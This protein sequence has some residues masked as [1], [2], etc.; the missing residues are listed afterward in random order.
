VEDRDHPAVSMLGPSFR[1]TD[2]IYVMEDWERS[3]TH[4][5][6]SLDNASVD[7]SK[8]PRADQDY[9]LGWCHPYGEG[10]V[11]YTAFGHFE[12]LWDERWFMDHLLG[13]IR[14]AAGAT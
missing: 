11:I 10:R 3:R 7:I 2:E 13:C 6:M 14:W 12:E 1:V 5:L 9:A 8:G 4:V